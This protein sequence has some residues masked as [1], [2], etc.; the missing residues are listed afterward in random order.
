MPG[1]RTGLGSAGHGGV[2]GRDGLPVELYKELWSENE[3][4]LLTVF[5]ESFKDMM[6]I[7]PTV[8]KR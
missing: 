6:L 4:D 2:P 5:N 8:S 3:E 7:N 1:R